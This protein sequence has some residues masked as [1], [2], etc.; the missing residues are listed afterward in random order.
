MYYTTTRTPIGELLLAGDG[1]VLTTVDLPLRDDT[2]H[3][4][5][6]ARSRDDG[7]FRAA[8]AQLEAYFAGERTD[9]DLPV[10]PAGTPFQRRV[11]DAL[12]TIPFGR[13]TSYGKV[14]AEIGSPGSA[15][16]VGL[17]NN[18][19]PIPL[20]IPC[21]RVVGSTGQ[22]VGYGGGLA[23]KRWLLDHEVAVAQRKGLGTEPVTAR[24]W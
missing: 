18:R 1:S 22:L 20:I 21:H 13:T 8:M 3:P 15:R 5:P 7:P 12:L 11:W 2:P 19:N 23:C 6:R 14:A 16:A 10:A 4:E 17:A 24:L 9:F